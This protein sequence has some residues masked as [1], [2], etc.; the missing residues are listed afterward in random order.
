MK[1]NNAYRKVAS[2]TGRTLAHSSL[3][4]WHCSWRGYLWRIAVDL[5]YSGTMCRSLNW[6]Q[7]PRTP[8]HS[9]FPARLEVIKGTCIASFTHAHARGDGHFF[10]LSPSTRTHLKEID[11]FY[12]DCYLSSCVERAGRDNATHI[13]SL[14]FCDSRP[15]ISA[16]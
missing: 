14:T 13:G 9:V 4:C 6:Q 15:R 1:M 2:V 8:V 12:T 11:I 5:V 16:A 7:A 3:R 10:F